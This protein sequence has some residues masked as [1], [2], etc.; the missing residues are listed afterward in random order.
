[1]I[2][3]TIIFEDNHESDDELSVVESGKLRRYAGCGL[4][5]LCAD[6]PSLLLFPDCLGDHGDDIDEPLYS[7][8]GNKL[9]TGNI[10]GFW[11][12]DGINVRVHSRFDTDSH[13]Y[14]FHYMLQRVAGV[15]IMDFKTLPDPENIWDFL[16]YLFPMVLK[17]AMRQG[18][19]RAYRVFCYDDDR[20]KGA[21]DVPRFIRRDVPFAGRAAYNTREHTANN[22]VLHLV[23]HTI[24]FIRRSAPVLLSVDQEMRQAADTIVQITPDYADRARSKV[25]AANLRPVRHP[26]YSAYTGLQKLCLQ[27]LRHEKLSFGESD[28]SICGVVFDAAWLWE[29]Y[30]NTIF[31][32]YKLSSSIV[33]PRNKKGTDPVYF[34]KEKRSPHYPDFYDDK[35][36][37]VLDAKYKHLQGGVSRDDLFQLISYLHVLGFGDEGKG[38][39]LYPAR[40]TRYDLDGALHGSGGRIGRLS[41]AV[42]WVG[43]QKSYS[44]FVDEIRKCENLFARQCAIGGWDESHECRIDV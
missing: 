2:E 8:V 26:F 5:K 35:H 40:S 19:F 25:I 38:V 14:F 22:H 10:V 31:R 39:L 12:V 42:P 6:N 28:G 41:F 44:D 7:I 11:G 3:K 27:I 33:H 29:E 17:R 32:Q 24:E 36:K 18:I 37:L 34:Y 15:N 21:I 1:M 9:W 20:V 13:Q 16:I 43:E 4:K 30:L 23:R